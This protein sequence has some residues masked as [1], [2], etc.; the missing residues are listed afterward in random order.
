M[1]EERKQILTMLAQGKITVDEAER[2]LEAT[3]QDMSTERSE[4]RRDAQSTPKFLHVHV[5][6]AEDGE[7]IN[8]RI[9]FQLIR[10]GM[11]LKALIPAHA[12]AKVSCALKHKGVAFDLDALDHD[13]IEELL[14]NLADLT[15]DVDGPDEKV[16]IFCE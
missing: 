3:Q 4:P 6:D 1:S 16:R 12:Q 10:A 5:D 11:K 14:A 7:K 2:L 15:V 8:I 13:T 9:P